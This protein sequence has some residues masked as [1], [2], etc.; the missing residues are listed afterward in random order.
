D[1]YQ[2]PITGGSSYLGRHELLAHFGLA[3][4]A[5]VQQVSARG[6]DGFLTTRR[7]VSTNQ[8]LV[9]DVQPPLSATPLSVG[10]PGELRLAGL[11]PN[12]RA[13]FFTSVRGPGEGACFPVF[14]GA[15]LDLD[16][17]RY[18]GSAVADALGVARLGIVV[19]DS[20]ELTTLWA[21]AAV[22]RGEGG[23]DSIVSNVL[24]ETV[25]PA[26]SGD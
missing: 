21:Q 23:V 20:P 15:C 11:P 14:A 12:Q 17:A 9:L 7:G 4:H 19:G 2:R 1:R 5:T 24:E 25:A 16:A 8:R 6:P 10:S 13:H 22:R 3:D 18:R 26:A